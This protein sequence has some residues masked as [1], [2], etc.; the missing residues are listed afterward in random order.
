VLVVPTPCESLRTTSLVRR[1]REPR[2]ACRNVSTVCRYVH[3]AV[4]RGHAV[5][6]DVVA[7]PYTTTHQLAVLY[8]ARHAF[9]RARG[10]CG[11]ADVC[12]PVAVRVPR[13]AHWRGINEQIAHQLAV[14]HRARRAFSRAHGQCKAQSR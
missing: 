12:E 1:K 7:I 3:T 13:H 8:R 10:R 9:T 2:P 11:S 5:M 14:L 6:K 4:A